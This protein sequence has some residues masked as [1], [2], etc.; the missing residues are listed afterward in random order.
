VPQMP[1]ANTLSATEPYSAVAWVCLHSKR[2]WGR[3]CLAVGGQAC[4]DKRGKPLRI[5]PH[6]RNRSGAPLVSHLGVAL[7]DV[8]RGIRLPGHDPPVS[9][10]SVR[11][12]RNASLAWASSPAPTAG[13]LSAAGQ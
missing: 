6:L 1:T 2:P 8:W 11:H 13:S 7:V 9:E 10:V 5:S 4:A 12:H 3:K